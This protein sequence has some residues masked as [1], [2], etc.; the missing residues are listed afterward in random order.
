MKD[1]LVFD[2]K[3]SSNKVVVLENPIDKET[4]DTKT[5][6]AET[7]YPSNGNKHIVASGRF[8][9]Q[10]GFDILVSAFAELK[11]KIN[12]VD[13]FIMGANDGEYR[14]E[15]NRVESLAE[16]L[17]VAQDLYCVGYQSNP[18][19]YVK[20]ADCFA[21]SSRWEGLPNV[22]IESLYLGTPVAAMK[23]VPVIERIISEGVNGSLAEKDDYHSLADALERVLNL[24]NAVCDY[25]GASNKAFVDLF[26]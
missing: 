3:I 17:G 19:K 10:K 6:D 11:K 21:L 22:V 5:I 12:D 8:C 24:Q 15:Y 18:Y 2:E 14:D 20:Y 25:Q 1:E 9:Y 4:I 13:L 23:C 16:S 26:C 7:P